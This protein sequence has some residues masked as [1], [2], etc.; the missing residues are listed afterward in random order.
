MSPFVVMALTAIAAGLSIPV[1][2]ITA[3]KLGFCKPFSLEIGG[4]RWMFSRNP[5]AAAAN[6]IFRFENRMNHADA[7]NEHGASLTSVTMVKL[8]A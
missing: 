7:H 5:H 3:A 8:A 1:A 6:T 4:R 2:A